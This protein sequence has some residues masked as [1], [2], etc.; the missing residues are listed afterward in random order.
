VEKL[1][2]ERLL[3]LDICERKLTDAEARVR[4]LGKTIMECECAGNERILHAVTHEGCPDD[5]GHDKILLGKVVEAS[6][7]LRAALARRTT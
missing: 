7:A 4:E 1:A 3:N 2:D 6:N 5:C